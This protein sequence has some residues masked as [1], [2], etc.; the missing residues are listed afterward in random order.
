MVPAGAPR[1]KLVT[2]VFLLSLLIGHAVSVSAQ[3]DI[4][5]QSGPIMQGPITVHLIFWLPSG[6]VYDS[7]ANLQPAGVGNYETVIGR[8]FSDVSG[9]S[10]FNIVSQY[11]GT[12]GAK[13]PAQQSCLGPVTLGRTFVDTRA[14]PHHGTKADPLQDSDIQSEIRT[15]VTNNNLNTGLGVEFFVF[16]AANVQECDSGGE[17]TFSNPGFCAY[18]GAFTVSGN[19]NSFIY[20]FMANVSSIS[21]CSEGVSTSPNGQISTDREIVAVSH[22]FFES[23][24]DPL[25][26]TWVNP[27][28]TEIGDNCN[29]QV[30]SVGRDGSNVSL[31]GHPYVVQQIWSNNDDGCFVSYVNNYTGPFIEHVIVTGNDDLRGDSEADGLLQTLNGSSTGV[32][33]K[34]PGEPG[35]GGNSTHV[36]V[37]SSNLPLQS[38][39]A[40]EIISLHSHPTWPEG[41][42]RWLVQSIDMKVRNPNG[43]L[44][45][46]QMGS[47]S[48]L[49]SITDGSPYIFPTPSCVPPPP[50]QETVM[51]SVFDDGYANLQGPSGAVYI[52]DQSSACIPSDPAVSPI[53]F[54]HKW[55]GR[56]ATVNT[57]SPVF[58]YV[59]DDGDTNEAGP[60]DAVYILSQAGA[61]K[62]CIPDGTATGTCRRWFGKGFT[63]DGRL[64]LVS[65]FD[66][67][68]TNVTNPSGAVYILSERDGLKACIPTDPS[69]SPNGIC[70][71]WFGLAVANR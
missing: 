47:G 69:V 61:M 48:P 26:S 27:G 54:C 9:N 5:D 59:F 30:G 31:N 29:Q 16:T 37:G 24:T 71:K 49:A 40:S 67:G 68:N 45:C 22:E 25:L 10:Y 34:A 64:V 3:T 2:F 17:C 58:F 8:F 63:K 14:Y 1:T 38:A 6:F 11:P 19:P 23:V 55:F 7:T 70:R 12:C 60:S 66:D 41:N 28:N 21:G 15:I 4:Q 35:W 39:A 18:H 43:T 33:R 52:H 51:F 44:V 20:A 53:G 65:V 56:A 50:D 57:S 36:R 46:E 42:D 13:V 32:F 62:A